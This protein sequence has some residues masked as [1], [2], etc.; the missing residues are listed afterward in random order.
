MNTFDATARDKLASICAVC[1]QS[2]KHLHQTWTAVLA[3]NERPV[4]TGNIYIHRNQNG[5][6]EQSKSNIKC[7]TTVMP[8]KADAKQHE[9]KERSRCCETKHEEENR[10]ANR[11]LNKTRSLGLLNFRIHNGVPRRSRRVRC[12]GLGHSI[13]VKSS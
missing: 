3:V 13:M 12:T 7:S 8:T 9:D 1:S 4:P 5:C 2:V 11:D 6:H 10:N